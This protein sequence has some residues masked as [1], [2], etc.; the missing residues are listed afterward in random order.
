MEEKI[1][2]YEYLNNKIAELRKEE[3]KLFYE[4][5]E[6]HDLQFLDLSMYD[7]SGGIE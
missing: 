1:C 2:K 5:K 6:C 7:K 3:L 4:G